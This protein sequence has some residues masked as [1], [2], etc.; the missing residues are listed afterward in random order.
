MAAVGIP[1]VTPLS[2]LAGFGVT[3]LLVTSSLLSAF[4]RLADL[5]EPKG[6]APSPLVGR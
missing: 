4:L 6:R 1:G 2:V 3:S 5:L